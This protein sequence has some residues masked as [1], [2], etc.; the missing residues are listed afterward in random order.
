MQHEDDARDEKTVTAGAA[1]AIFAPAL[2]ACEKKAA[3]EGDP[4]PDPSAGLYPVQRNP[5]Y[6]LDR[7]LTAEADATTYNNY[8]EFGTSKDIWE[9]AQ[10]LPIRPWTITI[11]GMVAKP[12][13]IDIPPGE[14]REV[15]WDVTAPAQLAQTRAEELAAADPRVQGHGP[16]FSKVIV[17]ADLID[18]ADE[19]PRLLDVM[20]ESIADNGGRSCVNASTIVVPREAEFQPRGHVHVRQG[21]RGPAC[22]RCRWTPRWPRCGAPA[23]RVR[24]GRRRRRSVRR[25]G[26]PPR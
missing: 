15:A 16:G 6:T 25:L 7:D 11:D 18:T 12:Q 23:R 3:A 24:R 22:S 10:A 1:G 4:I 21:S 8:Y 20:L 17:G 19:R 9:A 26:P 13:T 5:K 14:A 2:L